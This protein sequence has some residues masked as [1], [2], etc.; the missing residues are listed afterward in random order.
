MNE[1]LSIRRGFFPRHVFIFAKALVLNSFKLLANR[2]RLRPLGFEK[3]T[4]HPHL[5]TKDNRGT[6]PRHVHLWALRGPLPFRAMV[7]IWLASTDR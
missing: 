1:R 6:P 7:Y 5:H 4:M 3:Y 2:Y